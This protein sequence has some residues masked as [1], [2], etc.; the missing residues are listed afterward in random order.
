[1]CDQLANSGWSSISELLRC[2]SRLLCWGVACF[3]KAWKRLLDSVARERASW[4]RYKL[5]GERGG[6]IW[7][8]HFWNTYK[9][10]R[11]FLLLDWIS[12]GVFWVIWWW[13]IDTAVYWNSKG[14][15]RFTCGIVTAFENQQTRAL[16]PDGIHGAF[17]SWLG[18]R[19]AGWNGGLSSHLLLFCLLSNLWS[20]SS[21]DAKR[22]I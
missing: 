3:D 16:L 5:Y 6:R 15:T 8:H 18:G 12:W 9:K 14:S 13:L 22:Q 7:I 20:H 1:M 17:E 19:R 4:R 11:A 2:G 10:I 21:G